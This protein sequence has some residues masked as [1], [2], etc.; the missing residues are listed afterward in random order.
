LNATVTGFTGWARQG[1]RRP[2]L[3]VCHGRTADEAWDALL[4]H[5]PAGT[6]KAVLAGGLDPNDKPSSLVPRYRRL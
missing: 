3:A 6:D 2:W 1:K 5:A 4:D